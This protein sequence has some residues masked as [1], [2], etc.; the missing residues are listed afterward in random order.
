MGG[1]SVSSRLTS[2]PD[3]VDSICL[4]AVFRNSLVPARNTAPIVPVR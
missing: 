4:M 3:S 1:T 2:L